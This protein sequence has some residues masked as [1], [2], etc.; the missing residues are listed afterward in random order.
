M[1][2]ESSA[3]GSSA[4][5]GAPTVVQVFALIMDGFIHSVILFCHFQL[6]IFLLFCFLFCWPTKLHGIHSASI[7][8]VPSLSSR[9][10]AAESLEDVLTNNGVD[11]TITNDL[12]MEGWTCQ[13]FR[14][15]AVD[16]QGF[17]EVLDEWSS[18]HTLT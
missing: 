17:E 2:T 18:S 9:A 10:M 1:N 11:S 5:G 15:A 6:L 7:G 8:K 12:M 14:M 3:D 16:A 13:T 4:P